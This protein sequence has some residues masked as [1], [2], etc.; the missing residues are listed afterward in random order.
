MTTKRKYNLKEVQS[1]GRIA[2]SDDPRVVTLLK[3]IYTSLK[4]EK[5][6]SLT[7]QEQDWVDEI[8]EVVYDKITPEDT[9]YQA[10]LERS[11]EIL[12]GKK[13]WNIKDEELYATLEK[14]LFLKAREYTFLNFFDNLEETISSALQLD[15]SGRVPLSDMIDGRNIFNYIAVSLNLLMDKLETSVISMK[16][17]NCMLS[18]VLPDMSVIVTDRKGKIRFVNECGENLLSVESK[19]LIGQQVQSLFDNYG[20]IES[21]LNN[22]MHVKD[23]KVNLIAAK[24]ADALIPVMLTVPEPYKNRDESDEFVYQL[25]EIT[26]DSPMDK[27]F[28]LTRLSHDLLSPLNSMSGALHLIRKSIKNNNQETI[29]Y[30]NYLTKSKDHFADSIHKTLYELN[31]PKKP[32]ECK[33]I[34]FHFIINDILKNLQYMEGFNGINFERYI[35]NRNALHSNPEVIYSIIQNLISNAVKYRKSNSDAKVQISVVDAGADIQLKIQDNG[36]GIKQEYL[37]KIFEKTFRATNTVEGNGFGLFIIKKYI[38][39]LQGTIR[40]SSELGVGSVF[41]LTF[42]NMSASI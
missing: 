37:G 13:N 5:Q 38:E 9:E 30:F 10:I 6:R 26:R 1:T 40:V 20:R 3:E 14:V 33:L 31:T 11:Y 34:D 8:K 23:I 36:I 12:N 32:V 18:A 4:T 24:K 19:E 29:D 39:R 42:P 21:Q 22:R 7:S 16:A 27:A 28:E 17:V 15:F 25:L 2:T 35:A 41:T